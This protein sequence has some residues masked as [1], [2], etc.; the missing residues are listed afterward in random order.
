M[1]TNSN[2]ENV[3]IQYDYNTNKILRIEKYARVSSDRYPELQT[4]MTLWQ[5][6]EMIGLPIGSA[7]TSG[8][9]QLIFATPDGYRALMYNIFPN[10]GM[11]AYVTVLYTK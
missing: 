9:S 2:N 10:Q 1:F 3:I 7:P 8:S 6:V 11:D 4:G 5:V